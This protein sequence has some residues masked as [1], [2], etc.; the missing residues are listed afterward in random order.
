MKSIAASLYGAIAPVCLATLTACTPVPIRRLPALPT[1]VILQQCKSATPENLCIVDVQ[2]FAV[3]DSPP[4]VCRVAVR[5]V[6]V[7]PDPSVL[8]IRWTAKPADPADPSVYAFYDDGVFIKTEQ[9]NVYDGKKSE[10]GDPKTAL[11]G[12]G[13]LSRG[14][15]PSDSPLRVSQYGLKMYRL[16]Q[17][18]TKSPCMV[19]DP[20]IVNQD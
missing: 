10:S 17:D 1:G 9:G 13:M 5:Y 18:G 20:I 8:R 16:N 7:L 15:L 11:Y 3:T 4:Y 2:V 6:A 19:L 12:V 14:P